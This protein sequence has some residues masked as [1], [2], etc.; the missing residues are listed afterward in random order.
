MTEKT[1]TGLIFKSR[2][3]MAGL[4]DMTWVL[5]FVPGRES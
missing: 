4:H 1:A 2:N 5:D 3:E